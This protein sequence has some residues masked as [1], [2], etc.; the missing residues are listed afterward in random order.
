MRLPNEIR[1]VALSGLAVAAVFGTAWS[2]PESKATPAKTAHVEADP[3]RG[4]KATPAPILTFAG[5]SYFPVQALDEGKQRRWE[6]VRDSEDFSKAGR[7]IVIKIEPNHDLRAYEK[8]MVS[9]MG[10]ISRQ[11]HYRN[12]TRLM[13]SWVAAGP[14]DPK[15]QQQQRPAPAPAKPPLAQQPVKP[16]KISWTDPSFLLGPSEPESP[17]DVSNAREYRLMDWSLRPDGIQCCEV[18]IRDGIFPVPGASAAW[19]KDLEALVERAS[20]I[21]PAK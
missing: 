3:W 11:V 17:P 19:R 13:Q 9:K 21:V 5:E 14:P 16:V 4:L 1:S 10:V 8:A 20:R 6:F 12:A 2:A 15:Q 18:I 7:V